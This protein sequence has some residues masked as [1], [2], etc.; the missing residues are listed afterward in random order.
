MSD[1]SDPVDAENTLRALQERDPL[2]DMDKIVEFFKLYVSNYQSTPSTTPETFMRDML[3]G[4][5]R[6]MCPEYE[7]A[8]GF[9]KFEA[10]LK[11][12]IDEDLKR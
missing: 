12:I 6:S 3:Y 10:R 4:I 7:F 5:G 2:Y 9:L 11:E 1:I 8:I